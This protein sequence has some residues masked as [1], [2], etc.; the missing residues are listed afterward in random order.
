MVQVTDKYLK[1]F[2]ELCAKEGIGY[3][4]DAEYRDSASNLLSLVELL[5]ESSREDLLRKERLKDEPKGFSIPSEGK[6]CFVCHLNIFGDIWYDKYGLKCADCQTAF[7]KRVFPGYILKDDEHK[8]HITSSQLNWKFG[9]HPQTIKKLVRNGEL[10]ARQ[11]PKGPMIF[12][13]TE[14]PNLHEIIAKY[15][16][17]DAPKGYVSIPMIYKYQAGSAKD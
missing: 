16:K 11:I 6:T 10:K 4:T 8:R 12:L 17:K 15:K 5:L 3:E 2:K 13:K 14:N 9:I 7:K 1:E